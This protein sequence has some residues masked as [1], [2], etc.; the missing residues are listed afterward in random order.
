MKSTHF[1]KTKPK[2]DYY[3]TWK[4]QKYEKQIARM[5]FN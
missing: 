1:G 3:L 5:G 4:Q 2:G